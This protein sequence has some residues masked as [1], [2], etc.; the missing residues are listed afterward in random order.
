MSNLG[1]TNVSEDTDKNA[2]VAPGGQ[3]DSIVAGTNIDNIDNTDPVNPI[4]NAA[5][6]GG[7]A[8]SGCLVTH[9]LAQTISGSTTM[10]WDTEDYD[11]GGWHDNVTNPERLTVP[12]GVAFV[13]LSMNAR[14]TSSVTGQW[15]CTLTMNGTDTF[16][17]GVTNETETAGGDAVSA[18]SGVIAVIAGD[19][20]EMLC[21]ATS[22][23]TTDADGRNNFS[24]EKVG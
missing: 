9:T 23:R 15:N 16:V 20:F 7:G 10:T 2:P 24:I 12:S 5:A 4:I 18:V 11:V 21:F 22:S 14:D 17:G 1:G 8:F 6:S 3:V 19:Y 13:R